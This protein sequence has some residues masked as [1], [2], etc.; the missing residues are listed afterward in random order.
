MLNAHKRSLLSIKGIMY[1]DNFN[2]FLGFRW[3]AY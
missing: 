2:Y 3:D 1:A